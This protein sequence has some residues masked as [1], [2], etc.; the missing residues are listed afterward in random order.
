MSTLGLLFVVVS[1]GVS[2]VT[3]LVV[4]VTVIAVTSCRRSA[5]QGRAIA[6]LEEAERDERDRGF[7]VTDR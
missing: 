6:A 5:A 2:L 4:V 7:P 1:C 3:A